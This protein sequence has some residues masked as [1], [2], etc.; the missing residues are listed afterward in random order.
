[1]RLLVDAQLPRARA[2]AW[3]AR[4]GGYA[5]SVMLNQDHGKSSSN[6]FTSAVRSGSPTNTRQP[7]RRT[8]LGRALSA[9]LVRFKTSTV[10][11]WLFD[12][13]HVAGFEGNH[14]ALLFINRR[15]HKGIIL[16]RGCPDKP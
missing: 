11:A 7:F 3:R 16:R 13:Q 14:R 2:L 5:R 12:L 8:S 1:M 9:A 10:R 15:C 6:L 4:P